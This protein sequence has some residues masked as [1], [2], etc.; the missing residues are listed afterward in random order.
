MASITAVAVSRADWKPK[1]MS[2]P[3]TSL[4]MVLGSV[5]TL[6]PCWLRRLAVLWVPLPP[7]ITRQ[8]NRSASTVRSIL[9]SLVSSLSSPA[10][11]ISLKG[12]REVPRMVPPLVRMSEKSSGLILWQ[13]R[14]MR[15]R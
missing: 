12:W 11:C 2:V 5:T 15:P 10:F 8:S 6:T 14:S 4:S 3:H 13:S 9:A 7:R 1:V